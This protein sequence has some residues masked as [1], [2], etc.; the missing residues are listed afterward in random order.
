MLVQPP[1][2]PQTGFQGDCETPRW[3]Q[4]L[5]MLL[6]QKDYGCVGIY[7]CYGKV[8]SYVLS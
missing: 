2:N 3:D 8:F 6:H 5:P 7:T 4:L 1:S